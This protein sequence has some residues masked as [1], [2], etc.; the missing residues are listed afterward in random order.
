MSS[1]PR[2]VKK[3][4]VQVKDEPVEDKMHD[5]AIDSHILENEV[6]NWNL[7]RTK[8]TQQPEGQKG[9]NE[10]LTESPHPVEEGPN[11]DPINVAEEYR[12]DANDSTRVLEKVKHEVEQNMRLRSR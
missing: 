12:N 4:P 6:E 3:E 10:E 2:T 5:D 11:N 7:N 8:E 9:D 1:P